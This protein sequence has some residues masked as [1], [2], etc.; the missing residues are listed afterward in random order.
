M[1][2]LLEA[3]YKLLAENIFGIYEIHANSG[4]FILSL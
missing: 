1:K 2:S 4:N 3:P